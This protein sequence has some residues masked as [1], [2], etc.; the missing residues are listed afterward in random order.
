[1]KIFKAGKKQ[2]PI[3]AALDETVEQTGK[4]ARKRVGGKTKKNKAPRFNKLLSI[5]MK[6]MA[7][8]L[9]GTVIA[10][11]VVA[12]SMIS[13]SKGLIVDASYGKMTTY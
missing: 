11:T 7:L 1:M 10:A 4:K 9:G 8:V 13:Y 6:V 3:D 2:E 12:I 5:R